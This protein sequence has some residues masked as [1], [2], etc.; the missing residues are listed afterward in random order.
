MWPPVRGNITAVLRQKIREAK[1]AGDLAL[2]ATLR[3]S[4]AAH[5]A[6][7]KLKPRW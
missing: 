6:A 3:T 2:T 7:S 1:A 4:L 5:V